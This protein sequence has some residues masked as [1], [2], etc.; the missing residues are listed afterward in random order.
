[1]T[2]IEL[3][4]SPFMSRVYDPNSSEVDMSRGEDCEET[5]LALAQEECV[6][7]SVSQHVSKSRVSNEEWES[8]KPEIVQ[9]YLDQDCTLSAS[10]TLIER[11]YGIRAR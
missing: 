3:M 6:P 11:K 4:E 1:M 10:M 7:S 9:I 5:R 2:N 8:A